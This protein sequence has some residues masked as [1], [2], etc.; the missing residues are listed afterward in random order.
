MLFPN[1]GLPYLI[2]LL[3]I[4][5]LIGLSLCKSMLLFGIRL[6]LVNLEVIFKNVKLIMFSLSLIKMLLIPVLNLIWMLCNWRK[7]S[8]IK[9]LVLNG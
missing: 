8:G 5:F 4:P 1:A 7:F 9:N 3:T 2:L 6:F